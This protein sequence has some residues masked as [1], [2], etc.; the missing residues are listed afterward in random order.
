MFHYITN[1]RKFIVLSMLILPTI[2]L[3]SGCPALIVLELQDIET[4][5]ILGAATYIAKE[6]ITVSKD[7]TLTLQPGVRIV[8]EQ[9]YKMSVDGKLYAVGTEDNPIVFTGAESTRGFW[10]GLRIYN[11]NSTD[12]Q[13]EYVTIEYGGSYYDGNLLLTGSSSNPTRVSI[14]NCTFRQSS[15]Y[16]LVS[17][18]TVMID[19]FENNLLTANQAGAASMQADHIGFLK[20]TSSFTGNDLDRLLIPSGDVTTAASWPGI[21][22]F[23]TLDTDV[24]VYAALTIEQNAVLEFEAGHT[25]QVE[26]DGSLAVSGTSEA[27]VFFTGVETTPGY[28][29]GLRIYNSNTSDNVLNHGVFEYG[30]GYHDAN[31]LI[32][33]SSSNP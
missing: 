6:D 33:G 5:T 17:S 22:A 18:G 10:A 3:F 25:F 4:D 8:F 1:Y 27:P 2:M 32:T 20:N 9:D 13:L 14:N 31:V 28:W 29:G 12:N 30:G 26:P 19:G 16:G 7:A 23:Y 21:D 11:S 15:Q 24:N